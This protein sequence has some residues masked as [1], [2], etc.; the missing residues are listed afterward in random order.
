MWESV[1]SRYLRVLVLPNRPKIS[2][3]SLRRNYHTVRGIEQRRG[4]RETERKK[5]GRKDE[6]RQG[7]AGAQDGS[8]RCGTSRRDENLE[9]EVSPCDVWLVAGERW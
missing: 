5:E 9:V 4:K 8:L 3:G 2:P 1:G 6:V 7:A